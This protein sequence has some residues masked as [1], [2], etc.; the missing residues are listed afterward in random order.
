[1]SNLININ[2]K[3]SLIN[4]KLNV[5]NWKLRLFKLKLKNYKLKAKIKTTLCM[6]IGQQS[7]AFLGV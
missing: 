5:I 6:P 3:F 7:C 1:M 2:V 4:L